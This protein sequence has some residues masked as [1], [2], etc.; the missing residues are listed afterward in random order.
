MQSIKEQAA[1]KL[2]ELDLPAEAQEKLKSV[3]QKIN[4]VN[5]C[6]SDVNIPSLKDPS[7]SLLKEVPGINTNGSMPSPDLTN[8]VGDINV[9]DG[10]GKG[11]PDVQGKVSEV[12]NVSGK[13]DEYSK[14]AG[15]VASGNVDEVKSLPKTAEDRA[16]KFSG[17]QEMEEQ[18]N[19]L[20]QYKD[21]T[22]KVKDQEA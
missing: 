19:S 10:V 1:S 13:V 3:T 21:I 18:T 9:A 16:I 5:I 11:L 7:K 4:G 2:K 22:G 14:E 15:K 8:K 12:T 17:I 20:E 6:V